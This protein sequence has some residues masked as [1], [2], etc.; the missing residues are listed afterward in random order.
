MV[1]VA[2]CFSGCKRNPKFLHGVWLRS[3]R[4]D[5]FGDDPPMIVTIVLEFKPDGTGHRFVYHTPSNALD[6]VAGEPWIAEENPITWSASGTTIYLHLAE[7]EA[8]VVYRYTRQKENE[9]RVQEDGLAEPLR[10]NMLDLT[11]EEA[12]ARVEN[13]RTL[14]VRSD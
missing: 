2:L 7:Y 9:L 5:S 11:Y 1:S 6:Q 10:W 13:G 12:I 3:W 4:L 8:E 14:A